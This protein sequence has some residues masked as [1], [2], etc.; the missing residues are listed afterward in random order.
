MAFRIGQEV[1]CVD[2]KPVGGIGD[3]S[4]L[5][6]GQTYTV[7]W[8]GDYSDSIN[9]NIGICIRVEEICRNYP[10]PFGYAEQDCRD[11][12]YF[13]WRFRPVK[14]TD[15]SIFTELLTDLP[16]GKKERESA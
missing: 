9:G 10:V 4:P 6:S 5:K 11:V 1:V 15:I 7:R 13:A 16:V 14:T 2:D 3:T 12:P 8:I